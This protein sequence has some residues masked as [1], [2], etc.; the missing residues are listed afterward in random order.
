MAP[1]VRAGAASLGLGCLESLNSTCGP[2]LCCIL[3]VCP[4]SLG[5]LKSKSLLACYLALIIRGCGVSVMH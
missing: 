1:L 4:L 3:E 5:E 2:S